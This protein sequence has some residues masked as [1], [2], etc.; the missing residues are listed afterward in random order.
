MKSVRSIIVRHSFSILCLC[1]L[2]MAGCGSATPV[3][4][5]TPTLVSPSLT[6]SITPQSTIVV[7]ATSTEETYPTE[8][9]APTL[10][11]IATLQAGQPVT[12]AN[13]HMMDEQRGWGIDVSEHIVHTADGGHI[14]KDVTPPSGAFRNSGFFAFDAN[15]AYATPYYETSSLA[16]NIASVWNTNDGGDS[17]R[18]YQIDLNGAPSDYVPIAL[19]FLNEWN[20]WLL[21]NIAPDRD[22][23]YRT[24]NHGEDWSLVS[25]HLSG[26]MAMNVTGMVFQNQQTGWLSTSDMDTATNPTANWSIYQSTDA[27]HTWNKYQ[28]PAPHTLPE[29]FTGHIVRCGAEGINMLPP[30][31]LGVT[32]QCSLNTEPQSSYEYYFHSP[33]GGKT[34][35]SWPKTGDVE[36]INNLYGWRMTERNGSLSQIEKTQDGG[37]TWEK[38][39]TVQWEGDL[40]FVTPQVGWAIARQGDAVALVSTSDGGRTWVEIKPLI[41]TSTSPS[42]EL[43][44]PTP[45]PAA[46]DFESFQMITETV[47]WATAALPDSQGENWTGRI[48]RTGDGG[49]NWQDVSPPTKDINLNYSGNFDYVDGDHAWVLTQLYGDDPQYILSVW[50]TRDGGRTWKQSIVPYS[51]RPVG[52]YMTFDDPLHGLVEVVK[53][54]GAGTGFILPYKT[55]DGGLSWQELPQ[56]EVSRAD[57]KP[58]DGLSLA[59]DG[60]ELNANTCLGYDQS[61]TFFSA[62]EGVFQFRCADYLFISHTY[63][64]GQTWET[65]TYRRYLLFTS[66]VDFVDMNNGWYRA[67]EDT[68]RIP[69]EESLTNTVGAALYVTHDGGKTSS[70]IVPIISISGAQ[71]DIRDLLIDSPADALGNLHFIDLK[72]GFALTDHPDFDYSVLLKTTDGGYTWN[73]WVPHLLPAEP[74]H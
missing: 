12:L 43:P 11:A 45:D 49:L 71:Y 66:L 58:P 70:E 72:T 65:P 20:G 48:L 52:A 2:V 37:S 29:S 46:F 14:W 8:I 24:M 22:I 69:P 61:Q 10:T 30:S 73:G 31:T 7:T 16:P 41:E 63:D 56:E 23:L 50:I 62:L 68:G 59:L 51:A 25:D 40:D 19:P 27:G 47:G 35:V 55:S 74:G 15:T 13:L 60:T 6:P 26:S 3:K 39:K 18:E 28:L 54:Q 33:D 21:V 42:L 9:P 67:Q 34:W 32:I 5:P 17:W 53:D 64:G 38:V 4:Q 57:I 1:S 44:E 36:F